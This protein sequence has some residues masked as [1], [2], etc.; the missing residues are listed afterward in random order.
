MPSVGN[1]DDGTGADADLFDIV[2]GDTNVPDIE[3]DVES[4]SRSGMEGASGDA[5]D[6]PKIPEVDPR[7][8]E[9]D[10]DSDSY[11]DDETYINDGH[12]PHLVL[13]ESDDDEFFV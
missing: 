3:G 10:S 2:V 9:L 1:D 4:W 8:D 12:V 5:S 7:D 6:I 11:D 13:N